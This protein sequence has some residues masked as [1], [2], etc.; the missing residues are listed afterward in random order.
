ME[1]D[2]TTLDFEICVRSATDY[3]LD[4]QRRA[5][6]YLVFSQ[7][8]RKGNFKKVPDPEKLHPKTMREFAGGF[9]GQLKVIFVKFVEN[10]KLPESWKEINVLISPQR[11]KKLE[12]RN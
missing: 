2:S 12:F 5:S 6:G 9:A 8:S 4:P 7:D 10:G 11:K 1:G 3:P